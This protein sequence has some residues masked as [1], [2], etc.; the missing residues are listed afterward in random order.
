MAK[1][2]TFEQAMNGLR[3]VSTEAD[4]IVERE[5]REAASDVVAE[6]KGGLWP[7]L[8]GESAEG[9]EA[10]GAVIVNDVEH[11]EHVHDRLHERLIPRLIEEREPETLRRIDEALREAGSWED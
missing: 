2:L 6:L 8:T 10:V 5:M 9:F 3:L 7:R 1:R 4:G 11:T